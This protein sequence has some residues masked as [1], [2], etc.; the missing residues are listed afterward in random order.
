[1]SDERPQIELDPGELVLAVV[2][3]GLM[4]GL[5]IWLA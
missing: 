3:A 2:L 5:I 4:I 1:M